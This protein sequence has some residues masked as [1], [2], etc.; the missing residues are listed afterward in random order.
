MQKL[1]D[2]KLEMDMRD[3]QLL[4]YHRKQEIVDRGCVYIYIYIYIYR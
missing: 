3:V 1:L 2:L 4:D